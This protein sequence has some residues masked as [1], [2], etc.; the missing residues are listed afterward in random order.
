MLKYNNISVM[1]VEF[2]G[3]YEGR[4]ANVVFCFAV[5]FYKS[6][7]FLSDV[8]TIRSTLHPIYSEN[9]FIFVLQ[10]FHH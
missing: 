10:F 1:K 9:S 7:F 6:C 2:R 5:P 4:S 8:L 3:E